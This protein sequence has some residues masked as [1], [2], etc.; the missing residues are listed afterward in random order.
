MAG[1]PIAPAGGIFPG[2]VGE[3]DAHAQS[4]VR[5]LHDQVRPVQFRDRGDEAE[6]EAAAGGRAA[7]LAAVEAIE[8]AGMLRVRHAGAVVGHGH[9]RRTVAPRQ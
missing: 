3:A 2:V 9:F 7:G 8:D 6:A 1:S 5:I 4:R